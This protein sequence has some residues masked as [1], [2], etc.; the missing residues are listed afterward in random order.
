MVDGVQ[1]RETPVIVGG[2]AVT[3]IFAKPE[4]FV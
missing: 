2:A 4:I 1:T 3:V